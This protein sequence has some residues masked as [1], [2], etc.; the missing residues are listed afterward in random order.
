MVA[1]V[2][3]SMPDQSNDHCLIQQRRFFLL[4]LLAAALA[5]GIAQRLGN[6]VFLLLQGT[7]QLAQGDVLQLADALAGDAELLA[8]FLQRAGLLPVQA[9]ARINDLALALI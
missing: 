6:R 8:D 9:E 3:T 7:A 4:L 5:T 1:M 2:T